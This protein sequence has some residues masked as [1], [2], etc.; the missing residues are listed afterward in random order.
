[1]SK[2]ELT[3]MEIIQNL[4]GKRMKQ[5]EAAEMLGISERHVRRLLSAYRQDGEVGLISKRRGKPSNNQLKP[6]TKQ[7]VIDLLHSR[8]QDFGPTLAHEKISEEHGLQLSVESVRKIMIAEEIWQPRKVKRK[9]VHQLRPRRSCRG[10][11]VQI[12]GSPHA[13]FEER[14]PKCSLLAYI[15][16]ATGE[17]ME[18]YF[19]PA[20]TTFSYFEAT[21]RYLARHGRPV[22]FYSDKHGIFKI[23]VKNDLSGSGMTQFGRAMKTLDIEIICANTPQAKGRVERV[24]ETLQDRLVKELRLKGISTIAA[25]NDFVPEYLAAFNRR[26]AVKPRS[27][28]DAHRQPLFSDEELNLIFSRQETRTISKNLT[29]QYN[30]IIYQ[31]SSKRPSYAL[32]KAQ[33][34]V[35]ENHLGEI[36]ILYKGRPLQYAIF[37]KQLRQA[38]TVFAKDIDAHLKTPKPASDHPWRQYGRRISGKPIQETLTHGNDLS[39]P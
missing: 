1:M 23:N 7:Q 15:D 8:Y 34:T 11:L 9:P 5:K 38:Q 4:Q 36:S 24:I 25:A 35:C 18:L 6:E 22:A 13:W 39:T 26:F 12:D 14:G 19:A 28:H 30:K 10:E 17:L 16:D 3:R 33:V 21:R 20:E 31:I 27:N 32:R 37:R 2:K 29:L